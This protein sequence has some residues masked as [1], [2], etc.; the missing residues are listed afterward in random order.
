MNFWDERYNTLEYVYGIQPNEFVREMAHHIPK[1]NVLCLGEGEG[2]NAVFLAEHGYTV[3]AVDASKIGLQKAEHLAHSRGVKIQT[4]L[5]DL[6]DFVIEP[7]TWQGIVA[8][9]VHLPQSLRAR[10]HRDCVVGLSPGGVLV[11]EAFTPKQL[12]FQTGG[13]RKLELLMDLQSL[14]QEFKGLELMHAKE[15]ER[16][17]PEGLYHR[18]TAA[19]VQILGRKPAS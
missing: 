11:I 12:H 7:D 10:V 19:V 5:I 15:V 13:P 1:G 2:R 18:G 4:R 8:T 17:L 3:T 16:E 6:A 9:F 14:K